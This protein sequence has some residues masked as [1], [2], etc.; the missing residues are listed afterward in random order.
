MDIEDALNI[1]T[2]V[3]STAKSIKA[4]VSATAIGAAVSSASGAGIMSTLAT[5]GAASGG[6][7]V[8]GIGAVAGGAGAGVSTLLNQTVFEDSTE[9]KVGSYAGAAVGTIGSLS[10]L[11]VAGAGPTGLA[12]IGSIACPGFSSRCTEAFCP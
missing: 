8:A 3:A 10:A 1:T 11:A 4:V 2:V 7:V 6:G 5:A 9:A 12:S